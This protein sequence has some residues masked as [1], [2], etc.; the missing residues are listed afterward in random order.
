[1]NYG[2]IGE[3][4]TIDIKIGLIHSTIFVFGHD[5]TLFNPCYSFEG[6]K[7]FDNLNSNMMAE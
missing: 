4:K 1:M 3:R 7:T 5:M 6:K 2:R